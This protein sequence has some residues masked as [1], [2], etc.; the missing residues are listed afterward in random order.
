RH[1]DRPGPGADA[2]AR[3][4]YRENAKVCRVY[5]S[6]ALDRARKQAL[7]TAADGPRGAALFCAGLLDDPAT[8]TGTGT[9]GG[10]GGDRSGP[11]EDRGGGGEGEGEGAPGG[12]GP[13]PPG[14][15]NHPSIRPSDSP[16][17]SAPEPVSATPSG[18]LPEGS[19]E[20]ARG[21]DPGGTPDVPEDSW[22]LPSVRPV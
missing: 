1:R 7:E 19:P 2:E 5:R 9:G 20:D 17:P 16:P 15:P 4:W 18:P 3:R 14:P 12:P 11:G 8:G 6:G 21:G 13:A 22:P 10:R